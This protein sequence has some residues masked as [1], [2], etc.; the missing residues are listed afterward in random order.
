[1]GYQPWLSSLL[2]PVRV[3]GS[4]LLAMGH[5]PEKACSFQNVRWQWDLSLSPL[6]KERVLP[7]LPGFR[8]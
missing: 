1:M 8:K 4:G 6:G 3:L 2:G 5:S 7:K